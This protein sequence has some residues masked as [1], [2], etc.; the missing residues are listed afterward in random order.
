MN[1]VNVT[2]FNRRRREINNILPTVIKEEVKE[3]L[4]E[5]VKEELIEEVKEELIEEV[6]EEKKSSKPKVNNKKEKVNK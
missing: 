2:S 1:V 6:K 4:I 5:E 3:E